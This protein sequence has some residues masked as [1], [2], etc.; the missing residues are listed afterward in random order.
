MNY[1]VIF[2][3]LNMLNLKTSNDTFLITSIYFAVSQ[4]QFSPNIV[5]FFFF[6][7]QKLRDGIGHDVLMKR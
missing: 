3:F 7:Y 6:L 4:P 5:I 1:Q 2:G